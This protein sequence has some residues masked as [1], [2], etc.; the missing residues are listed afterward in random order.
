MVA[1]IVL[2]IDIQRLDSTQYNNDRVEEIIKE[3]KLPRID[4]K[5]IDSV[6]KLKD[7]PT[8]SVQQTPTVN[9]RANPFGE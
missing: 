4:T 3:N 5:T 2:M 6:D 8:G 1:V 9:N 7:T